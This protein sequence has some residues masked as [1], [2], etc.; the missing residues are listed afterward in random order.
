MK[1][2]L[3]LRIAISLAL[4]LFIIYNTG[5][6]TISTQLAGIIIPLFLLCIT[7]ENIGVA[8]SAKKWHLLL[9]AKGIKI[10]YTE[11]LAYYYIGSF[12]NAMMPSSIGGD[13]VKSYK[14]G[15]KTD[16]V[17][18]FSASIMDRI[19]GLIAVVLIALGAVITSYTLVPRTALILA[20]VLST[21][22]LFSLTLFLKTTIIERTI[23]MIFSRWEH[24]HTFLN[25]VASS[26]KTYHDKKLIAL[27]LLFSIIFHILLILNNYLLSLALGLDIDLYYFF[28]FI[29]IAEILVSLPISIQGF[30]V[31][32]GTYALLFPSAGVAKAASFSLGFLDQIVKVIT[33]A[34]GGVVY[35]LKK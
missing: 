14:L 2:R 18:A 31:R 1:S 11:S 20:L 19:T 32:E 21:L 12:F 13:V 22:F 30:G 17:E 24:I 27:T 29:P 6:A 4:L 5:V 28:I 8:I 15:I 9:N 26:L 35:V 10:G 7:V 25:K 34:I 23:T 16:S 33:S 3:I